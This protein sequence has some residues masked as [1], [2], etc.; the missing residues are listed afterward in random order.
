MNKVFLLKAN[1]EKYN[2]DELYDEAKN[3]EYNGILWFNS[4][5]IENPMD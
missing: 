3:K 5:N 1:Y 2:F 4:N